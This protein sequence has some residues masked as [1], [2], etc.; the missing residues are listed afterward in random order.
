LINFP[1]STRWRAKRPTATSARRAQAV[2]FG[3]DLVDATAVIR[4]AA[5][6]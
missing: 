6:A 1:S 5:K 2:H 4:Q 3:G